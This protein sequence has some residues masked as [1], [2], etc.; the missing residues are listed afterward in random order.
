MKNEKEKSKNIQIF[1]KKITNLT[2]EKTKEKKQKK[3]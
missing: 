2:K 1:I 3:R